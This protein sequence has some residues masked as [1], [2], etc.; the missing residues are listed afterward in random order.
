METLN[1]K[2]QV[3]SELERVMRKFNKVDDGEQQQASG[4]DEHEVNDE[5]MVIF[6]TGPTILE[7]YQK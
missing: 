6:G 4:Q 5:A 3:Y 1:L 7:E 2:D